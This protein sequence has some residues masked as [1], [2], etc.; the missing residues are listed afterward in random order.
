MN[1]F[2]G[3]LLPIL[4]IFAIFW[5]FMI[6]PQQRAAKKRTEMLNKL[7][8]GDEIETVARI[9]GKIVEVNADNVILQIG[10]GSDSTKVKMHREGIARVITPEA[11]K[12]KASN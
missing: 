6:L 8:A 11:D 2:L 9:F 12:A 1:D 4:V 10:M 7:K 3:S 5:L